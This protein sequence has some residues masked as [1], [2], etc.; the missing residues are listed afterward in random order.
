MVIK[1]SK[2]GTRYRLCINVEMK[3]ITQFGMALLVLY[4]N[5]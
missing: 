5:S 2:D 1:A 3:D 4:I